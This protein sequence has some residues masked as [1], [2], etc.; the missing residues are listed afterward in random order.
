MNREEII[1]YLSLIGVLVL[2]LYLAVQPYYVHDLDEYAEKD[3]EKAQ[4]LYDGGPSIQEVKNFY[5]RNHRDE[6]WT[7]YSFNGDSYL[8]LRLAR[9]IKENGKI[10]ELRREIPWV[11]IDNKRSQNDVFIGN[12]PLPHLLNFFGKVGVFLGYPWEKTIYF[13]PPIFSLVT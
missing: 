3:F 9:N 10:G 1:Q 6:T 13:F 11:S 7:P 5:Q 4:L 12:Y 8:W 2:Y